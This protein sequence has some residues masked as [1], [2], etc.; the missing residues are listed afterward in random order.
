M[1]D[2]VQK[3]G[4][5]KINKIGFASLRIWQSEGSWGHMT[6]DLGNV[7]ASAVTWPARGTFGSVWEGRVPQKEKR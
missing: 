7:P 6:V 1:L 5:R 2:L 3:S 4:D